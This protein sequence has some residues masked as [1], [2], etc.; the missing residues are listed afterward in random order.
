[1]AA[2]LAGTAAPS[3]HLASGAACRHSMPWQPPL[4]H[5]IATEYDH[6]RNLQRFDERDAQMPNAF[7][8]LRGT[9][10]ETWTRWEEHATAEAG[11]G[12]RI[13]KERK[14]EYALGVG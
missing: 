6:I 4:L 1:M 8:S 13:K 12:R 14:K 7:R 5:S 11:G 3:G 2:E 10:T 9:R